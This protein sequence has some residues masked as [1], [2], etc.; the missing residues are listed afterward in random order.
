MYLNFGN[1]SEYLNNRKINNAFT[2]NP[3]HNPKS[4]EKLI[5][6]A[7]IALVRKIPN[8]IEATLVRKFTFLISCFSVL[9]FMR[10]N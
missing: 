7:K 6:K 10:N 4:F 2:A 9:N 3:N 5:L 8:K 1:L